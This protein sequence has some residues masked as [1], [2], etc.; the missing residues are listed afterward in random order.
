MHG[1]LNNVTSAVSHTIRQFKIVTLKRDKAT[2]L[3]YVSGRRKR[4]LVS[5]ADYFKLKRW[6]MIAGGRRL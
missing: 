4:N 1:Q 3:H 5:S 2:K 6:H